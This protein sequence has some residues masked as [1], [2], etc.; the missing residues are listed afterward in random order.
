M[1]KSKPNGGSATEGLK[2]GERLVPV[3]EPVRA[4]S[5]RLEEVVGPVLRCGALLSVALIGTGLALLAA[6]SRL[7][8][9]RLSALGGVGGQRVL[10]TPTELL[11][12]LGAADPTA[13]IGLGLLVLIATPV[14]RVAST[15]VYFAWKRDRAYLAITGFVLL[16]LLAGFFLGGAS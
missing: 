15:V 4:G 1:E 5:L 11:S 10:H 9:E 6:L 2:G 16:V 12:G 7:A 3:V 13:L 14:V 8:P